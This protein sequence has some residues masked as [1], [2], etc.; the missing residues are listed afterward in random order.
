M[1]AVV[2]VK[3]MKINDPAIETSRDGGHNITLGIRGHEVLY[4]INLIAC[5][6]YSKLK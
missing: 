2:A 5:V 6:V 1:N 4:Q 3:L